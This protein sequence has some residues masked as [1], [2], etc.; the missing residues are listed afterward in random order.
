MPNTVPLAVL[1]A[2]SIASLALPAQVCV[3]P[4]LCHSRE[5]G[6]GTGVWQA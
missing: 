2:L 6:L 4:C 3:L 5:W 1:V